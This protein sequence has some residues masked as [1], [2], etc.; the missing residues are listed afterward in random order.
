MA[1]SADAPRKKYG[2]SSID[3]QI[4]SALQAEETKT[5]W[6]AIISKVKEDGEGSVKPLIRE[7]LR[8]IADDANR[9][10][11]ELDESLPRS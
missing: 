4:S 10:L 2:L 3:V 8:P 6:R 9:L 11:Q 7:E 1:E 5:I